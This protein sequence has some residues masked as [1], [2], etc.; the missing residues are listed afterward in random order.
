MNKKK[1][2]VYNICFKEKKLMNDKHIMMILRK[3]KRSVVWCVPVC[4]YLNYTCVMCD[5]MYCMCGN[6]MY[7]IY[8][9]NVM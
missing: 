6:S 2:N 4:V 3:I 7:R 1:K 9:C 5:C 8:V